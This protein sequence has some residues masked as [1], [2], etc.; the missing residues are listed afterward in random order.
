MHYYILKPFKNDGAN[1]V[2]YRTHH[3]S[4]KSLYFEAKRSNKKRERKK[5]EVLEFLIFISHIVTHSKKPTQNV[6]WTQNKA[7]IIL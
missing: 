1:T 6:I 5:D 4:M 3:K 7:E 2:I